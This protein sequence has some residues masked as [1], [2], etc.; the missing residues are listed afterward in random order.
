MAFL[1][2]LLLAFAGS[3]STHTP[4][5]V[6]ASHHGFGGVVQPDDSVGIMSGG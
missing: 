4:T 6:Q 1:L 5:H 3:L 2:A